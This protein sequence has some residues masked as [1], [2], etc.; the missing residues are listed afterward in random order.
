[1]AQQPY[2]VPIRHSMWQ[3]S[4]SPCS[5][6]GWQVLIVFSIFSAWSDAIAI[7][8]D[9]TLWVIILTNIFNE[10]FFL[11]C[12]LWSDD[13][14]LT[15]GLLLSV[16]TFQQVVSNIVIFCIIDSYILIGRLTMHLNL[17]LRCWMFNKCLNFFKCHKPKDCCAWPPLLLIPLYLW[18]C[19][20]YIFNHCMKK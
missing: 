4:L 7:W 11:L 12:F 13:L 3:V 14:H 1:M 20:E 8:L 9:L 10:L 17:G 18:C 2:S 5:K 16:I 15:I 19:A 6:Y